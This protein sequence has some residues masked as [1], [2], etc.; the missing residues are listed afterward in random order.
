MRQQIFSKFLLLILISSSVIS[1]AR[2]QQERKSVPAPREV[3]PLPGALDQTPVLNSNS[4][5]IVTSNGILVSTFPTQ[6]GTAHLDY[7]FSNRF[8][9][10]A[11]H[12]ASSAVSGRKQTVCLG[13]I[14]GNTS[15]SPV[16]LEVLSKA[17]Y[18]SRPDA[19]FVS[20]PPLLANDRGNKY[21]GPG[22]RVTTE[23]LQAR[24]EKKEAD[25]T[26]WLAPGQQ[27]VLQKLT[28]PV[29]KFKPQLNGRTYMAQIRASGPV[30]LA[31]VSCFV[32]RRKPITS[33]LAFITP[34]PFLI[35]RSKYRTPSKK[36]FISIL[37]S[38]ARVENREK[39]PTEPSDKG[40]LRYGRVSGVSIG[41]NWEGVLT[42]P[43]LR[44]LCLPE[45]NAPISYIIS[46]L[47]G[48]TFGTEQ[49]QSAQLAARN[50]GTAYEAH[51]NYG[52]RYDLTMPL[53][54]CSQA[55]RS[56]SLAL[57]TPIKSNIKS[58]RVM[59]VSPPHSDVYFRGT[60]KVTTGTGDATGSIK[61]YHIV[62]RRGEK[63]QPFITLPLA[64][65]Q[66][67]TVRIEFYYPPDCT[68]PH[69]LTVSAI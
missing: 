57:E 32:Q 30:R 62:Q 44:Y 59:F 46:S 66:E 49:V 47:R 64:P 69:L 68:P 35:P 28:I 10:F 15:N 40:L 48:G 12:V 11:H 42:D 7:V 39:P 41:A 53:K 56:V 4:P 36:D 31:I 25:Q 34:V 50:P 33:V 58:E 17:S 6:P 21:A 37:R 14:A 63:G 16:K 45:P 9:V 43:G 29:S 23:L 18:L 2:A 13:L 3:R 52:V 27:V 38:G 51:G 65:G 5:E 55:T 26:V 54:N 19:P 61:F 22:D 8:D 60:L 67:Q 20:L 24:R 1:D